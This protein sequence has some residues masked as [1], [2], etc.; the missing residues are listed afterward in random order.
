M[1]NTGDLFNQIKK[2][3][4]TDDTDDEKEFMKTCSG[5]K[6]TPTILA[7]VD[8]IFVFGD[9]HGDITLAYELF[10]LSNCVKI[11]A[12]PKEQNLKNTIVDPDTGDTFT[13]IETKHKICIVQVGDQIDRCRPDKYSC[14]QKEATINDEGSDIKILKLFNALDK[15]ASN[16]NCR[17]ISLLGNHELMNVAGNLNYVSYE[18]LK[19]FDDKINPETQQKFKSGYEARTFLFKTG[20]QYAKLLGCSRTATIIIGSNLFIHAGIIPK[21]AEYYG[22]KQDTTNLKVINRLIRKWLLGHLTDDKI[23]EKYVGELVEAK[24]ISPFWNRILGTLPKNININDQR[25]TKFLK[26][27]LNLLQF[28]NMLINRIVVGHTPQWHDISIDNK[29]IPHVDGINGTCGNTIIRVDTGSSKA[30]ASFDSQYMAT[31]VISQNRAPQILEINNEKIDGQVVERLF[32]ISNY[33][34]IITRDELIQ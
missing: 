26:K 5:Y 14:D 21:I 31:G 7:T 1:F 24:T 20:N 11:N 12:N 9:I 6:Y 27:G 13:W 10:K 33:N 4:N 25:C 19:Q 28:D 17:V 18:G 3:Y 23:A 32:V 22:I 30:F 34:N 15:L 8:K 16:F 2:F 29:N